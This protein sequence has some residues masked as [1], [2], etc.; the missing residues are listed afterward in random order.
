KFRGVL[1]SD[2]YLKLGLLDEIEVSNPRDRF[3]FAGMI[4]TLESKVTKSGKPFG[5]MVV[6][7]FT[8]SA[9][10]VMW[11]ESFVPARDAGVLVPGKVIRFKA[12]IQVDDRTDTRRLTGSEINE[13]K[14]RGSS[15]TKGAVE[16]TLWTA[17][18]SER[19]LREIR[20]AIS[21]SPGKVPVFLHF[22]NSAGRRATVELGESFRVKRTDTLERALGRWMD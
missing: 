3:P 5:V 15:A 16:L 21:S 8:G 17:R 22:Q 19:D 18:H 1:D 14:P 2:K 6:E 7:D 12:Q 11:G 10:V 13:L 20:D 9:E 4:R